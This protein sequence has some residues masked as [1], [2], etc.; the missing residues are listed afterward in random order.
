MVREVK[1]AIAHALVKNEGLNIFPS[2]SKAK[3]MNEMEDTKKVE[4][5]TIGSMV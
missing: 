4:K 2:N 3:S 5:E 1:I